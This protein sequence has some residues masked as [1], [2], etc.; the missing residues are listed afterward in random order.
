MAMGAN[1]LKQSQVVTAVLIVE[2]P[3]LAAD[4]VKSALGLEPSMI[5]GCRVA[6]VH[7]KDPRM[8]IMRLRKAISDAQKA[9]GDNPN[10]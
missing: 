5:G 6:S 9:L 3:T 1:P 10:G 2:D 7:Y 8:E 4:F